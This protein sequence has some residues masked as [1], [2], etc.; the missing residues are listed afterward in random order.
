MAGLERRLSLPSGY[1]LVT[2]LTSLP[3]SPASLSQ[4]RRKD[5]LVTRGGPVRVRYVPIIL[6]EDG[7]EVE[8]STSSLS[9]ASI[10]TQ[11]GRAS[12][13][14]NTPQQANKVKL[15]ITQNSP[16]ISFTQHQLTAGL[17][18]L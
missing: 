4:R 12:L 10:V 7:E 5:N 9:S 8:S 11:P 3:C 6:E 13:P 2:D 17:N 14:S 16:C 15:G 1:R 18:W